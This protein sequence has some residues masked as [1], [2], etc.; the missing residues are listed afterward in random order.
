VVFGINSDAYDTSNGVANG[1]VIS[2]GEL[3]TS[4]GAALGWGMTKDGTVKYGSAELQMRASIVGGETLNLAHVNK[5]RKT[6]TSGVF[7]L[8]ERFNS[9]TAST[10]AGVEVI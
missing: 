3:V 5:E 2:N 10:E 6:N 9:V 1:L 8:T 4:S 7:L